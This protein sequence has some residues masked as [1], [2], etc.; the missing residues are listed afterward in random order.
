MPAE[1]EA[2]RFLGMREMKVWVQQALGSAVRKSGV[3]LRF[4]LV[5]ALL[6]IGLADHAQLL[7]GEPAVEERA[8]CVSQEV[9]QLRQLAARSSRD[10]ED[11]YQD[12]VTSFHQ[13]RSRSNEGKRQAGQGR[14]EK[15]MSREAETKTEIDE[16]REAEAGEVIFRITRKVW[17]LSRNAQVYHHESMEV[18]GCKDL[19]AEAFERYK[20]VS[21]ILQGQFGS[22]NGDIEKLRD[23]CAWLGPKAVPLRKLRELAEKA[24]QLENQIGQTKGQVAALIERKD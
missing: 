22:L 16:K 20:N 17:A 13:S 10:L 7:A 2:G 11:I 19:D 3:I 12:M 8:A 14:D 15:G 18:A 5:P 1:M 24:A 9:E 21:E 6:L 23:L 4:G